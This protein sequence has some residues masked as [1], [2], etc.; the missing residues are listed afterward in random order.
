ME[1]CN[2]DILVSVYDKLTG[3]YGNPCLVENEA[4]A[5]RM[6]SDLLSNESTTISKHP[7]DFELYRLGYFDRKTGKIYAKFEQE[8][9]IIVTG[10]EAHLTLK[11]E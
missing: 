6:F 2:Y 10:F 1:N 3:V 4:T 9:D 5:K 8:T 7:A 11:G